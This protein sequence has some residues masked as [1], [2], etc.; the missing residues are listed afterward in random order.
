M[1]IYKSNAIKQFSDG[2]NLPNE[3]SIEIRKLDVRLKEFVEAEDRAFKSLMTFIARLKELNDFI[4][5]LPAELDLKAFEKAV[6]LRLEVVKAFQDALSFMS[7]AEHEKSH[8][9]ESYGAL[10][11]SLDEAFKVIL[12]RTTS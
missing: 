4:D 11:F 5:G 12:E 6:E 10:M 3:L 7:K 1:A 2:D 9:L 8:L